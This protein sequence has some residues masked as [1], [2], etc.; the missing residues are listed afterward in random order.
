MLD[1]TQQT[2]PAPRFQPGHEEINDVHVRSILVYTVGIVGFF[3]ACALGLAW[4]DARLRHEDAKLQATTPVLL[5]VEA[6]QYPGPQLQDNPGRDLPA[7]A[8]EAEH[9][10][11]SY[12]WIEKG[13]IARI[14]IG[15]AIAIVAERG[16]SGDVQPPATTDPTPADAVRRARA[17]PIVEPPRTPPASR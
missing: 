4:V 9:R 5:N 6:G 13:K 11:G 7:L 10:L 1:F 17:N 2:G 14:P 3:T 8:A 16:I 12:G 15:R